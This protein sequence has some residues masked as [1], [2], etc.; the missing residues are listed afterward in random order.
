MKGEGLKIEKKKEKKMAPAT[1][2]ESM[3][4]VFGMGRG[5][6][7]VIGERATG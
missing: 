7:V 4:L 5:E 6:G 2:E 3:F 1:W